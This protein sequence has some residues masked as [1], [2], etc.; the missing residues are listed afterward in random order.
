MH[1]HTRRR[2]VQS[3]TYPNSLRIGY[4]LLISRY[5]V[6][7]RIVSCAQPDTGDPFAELSGR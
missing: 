6:S 4:K 3:N 2:R 5:F 1:V 7:N